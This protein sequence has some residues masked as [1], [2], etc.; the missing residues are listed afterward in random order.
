MHRDFEATIYKVIL[1]AKHAKVCAKDA[2]TN[3]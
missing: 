1:T 2:K 3:H